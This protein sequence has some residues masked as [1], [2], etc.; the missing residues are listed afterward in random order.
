LIRAVQPGGGED[1]VVLD[2]SAFD[3]SPRRNYSLP[4]DNNDEQFVGSLTIAERQPP[5]LA[6]TSTRLSAG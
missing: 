5:D 3:R 2:V 6:S 4:M 1:H